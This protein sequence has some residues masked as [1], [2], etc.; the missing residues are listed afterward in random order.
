LTCQAITP[1]LTCRR[2][3]LSA[4]GQQVFRPQMMWLCATVSAASLMTLIDGNKRMDHSSMRLKRCLLTGQI[5]ERLRQH[6][7]VDRVLRRAGFEPYAQ[8]LR[9]CRHPRTLD[10][11]SLPGQHK[12]SCPFI[13]AVAEPVLLVSHARIGSAVQPWPPAGSTRR[14]VTRA[15]S[16]LSG[17]SSRS[18]LALRTLIVSPSQGDR[19]P[20]RGL[21]AV[22]HR[23][24]QFPRR[25]SAASR[26][27]IATST[28]TAKRRFADP[29][30][31]RCPAWAS[32][33][34][35]VPTAWPSDIPSARRNPDAQPKCPWPDR[36]STLTVTRSVS[37]T[38]TDF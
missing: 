17:A 10:L 15:T 37:R 20:Q 13:T 38:P 16:T 6:E 1:F 7:L 26:S 19:L 18:R 34:L 21:F 33:S 22:D 27:P 35:A 25:R 2:G 30:S 11:A 9:H 8:S 5:S 29:G 31:R 4:L 28:P 32:N 24:Q 3:D 14:P 12:T 23:L 36:Q